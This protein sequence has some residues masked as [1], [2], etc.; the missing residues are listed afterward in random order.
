[1]GL[2]KPIPTQSPAT[3]QGAADPPWGGSGAP[4]PSQATESAP[5]V[6]ASPSQLKISLARAG[7]NQP[8]HFLQEVIRIGRDPTADISFDP[9]TELLVSHNQAKIVRLDG[10]YV[11]FD[12]DS[13]NGTF[14]DGRR[15]T[16]HDLR[17]GSV[18]QLGAGGPQLTVSIATER[19]TQRDTRG[20]KRTVFGAAAP[21]DLSLGNAELL[22]EY[23]L[24]RPLTIGRDAACE[25]SLDSMYVSM[26]H[27]RVEPAGDGVLLHDLNSA[28]GTFLSGQ[29]ITQA[30]L[31]LGA[32]FVVGP[33]LLKYVPDKIIA[34]DT[35]TR[36]WVDA[37]DLSR[38]DHR[39][40]RR[41]LDQVSLKIEPGEFVCILGPSGCGKSTLLKALNGSQR[42][43]T[44]QVLLNNINYYDNYEQLKHQVGYVPQDDIIHPQLTIEKTLRYAAKLR[45]PANTSAAKRRERIDDVLSMLELYDHRHKAVQQLSGGQR[46]RVSIA[47]E[48][49][50]EPA[51]IYLDEPTSGLDP[52]LEEKLMLLLRELTL[53][54]KT[55]VSVTHTL[56]NILLADKVTF[57]VDGKLAFY[58]TP[59]QAKSFFLVNKLP[60]VYKRFEES[61]GDTDALRQRF[62]SSEIY[63]RHVRSKLNTSASPQ[64]RRAKNRRRATG[65]GSLRQFAVLTRRYSEIITKDP[66]NTLILLLQAPIVALF[67]ALAVRTD[68]PDRGPTSTMFLIMSLSALWFGCSNAARELTKEARVYARERMVNLR[69]IPYVL[70]KFF[71]LQ[72]LALLQVATM[73]TLVSF[74]RSGYVL[75]QPPEICTR[76]GIEACSRL[77]LDGVPG[78]YWLQLLN[79][80]LTALNGI[81]LGLLVSALVSNSDKAMSL[82]P[83]LLIPQVL[84][85]GSFGVPQAD[86]SI[87]RGAGYVMALNW[88][89]DQAKR[90]AICTPEQ[91][92]L[93]GENATGC[94]TCL[95]GYDPFKHKRLGLEGQDDDGRCAA[96]Q[97][98]V[99]QMLEFPETLQV[100]EDGWYTPSADQ[101]KGPAR[102][103]TK[104]NIGLLVLGSYNLL[105]FFLVCLFVRLRGHHQ[106]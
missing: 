82:V 72:W 43:E 56:D 66:R 89:L 15:I 26:Q 17:S 9:Q 51:V 38:V 75:T 91:E 16:R 12:L 65:P 57:L 90:I 83:L 33:Y 54:G 93:K 69:V 47:V 81:G 94:T 10:T 105:L 13:T 67:V 23:P 14:V 32:E 46:K 92:Q 29:R 34:F 35:R 39:T 106:S 70:S 48:L 45:L 102:L 73:L 19:A 30:A 104:S 61:A 28:N 87:K 98:A 58:G 20:A 103:A 53:R 100:V 42:A 97:P 24:N 27:S 44:G 77:I 64:E 85:S 25:I 99:G 41:F 86:E 59:E 76:F 1:V 95:H 84:F 36:T 7:G 37:H 63:Q 3:W 11:I 5:V 78:E 6:G 52:N 80:Y 21:D 4:P 60:E 79:L 22:G 62:E 2:D 8:I 18:I 31:A 55:V 40:K 101:G 68:Q 50:T 96:I 74:L 71:V 88:S 49:L